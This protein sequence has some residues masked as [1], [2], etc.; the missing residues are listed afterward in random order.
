MVNVALAF[1]RRACRLSRSNNVR[2]SRELQIGGTEFNH[3]ASKAIR[4]FT[5]V[6]GAPLGELT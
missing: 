1:Q 3:S 4:D 5:V 2:S 6:R